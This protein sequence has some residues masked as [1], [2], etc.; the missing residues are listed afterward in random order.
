MIEQLPQTFI[1]REQFDDRAHHAQ[2]GACRAARAHTAQ[3]T[4]TQRVRVNSTTEFRQHGNRNRH[5]REHACPRLETTDACL[6]KTEE[7]FGV[8]KTFFTGKAA[9]I[10]LR[11]GVSRQVAVRHQ[12]P[13]APTSALV[14]RPR[15]YQKDVSR[16]ALGVPDATPCTTPL[17]RRP[18]QGI[19]PAPA[20][21]DPHMLAGL[22][23]NDVR[24]AQFIEQIE[25]VHVGKPAICRQH[26][27]PSGHVAQD[28]G[29]ERADKLALIEAH[30]LFQL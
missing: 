11:H 20:T 25:Q 15:L 28:I 21:F 19:K 18:A 27:A 7:A 24:N 13:D 17:I 9:R 1:A 29:K 14:T 2:L 23:P 8:T 6:G 22:R 5:E 16:I 4:I 26:E 12:V 10:L 30:P 3:P